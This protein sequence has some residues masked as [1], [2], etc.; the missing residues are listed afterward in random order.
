MKNITLL[1]LLFTINAFAQTK[2]INAENTAIQ[3]SK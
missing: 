1:F 2:E 3:S